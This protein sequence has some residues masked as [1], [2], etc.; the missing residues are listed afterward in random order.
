MPMRSIKSVVEN[1]RVAPEFAA[2][3]LSQTT[4]LYEKD[5]GVSQLFP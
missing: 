2:F 3:R 1:R 4:Y 5:G